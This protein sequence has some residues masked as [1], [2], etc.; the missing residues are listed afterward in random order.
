MVVLPNP[1]KVSGLIDDL[2]SG[3]NPTSKQLI[4][5]TALAHYKLVSIHPFG[6]GMAGRGDF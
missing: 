3:L 2:S 1:I 5:I 4:T 6:E